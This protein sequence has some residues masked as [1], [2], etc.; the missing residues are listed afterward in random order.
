M[1]TQRDIA[2]LLLPLIVLVI[3]LVVIIA[4][5]AG[6]EIS[7]LQFYLA[8]GFGSLS[9]VLLMLSLMASEPKDGG[10]SS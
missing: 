6:A 7:T 3:S 9:L 5:N 1:R 4:R 2:G 10:G 8:C